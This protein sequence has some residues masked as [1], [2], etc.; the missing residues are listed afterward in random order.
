LNLK[1]RTLTY[2]LAELFFI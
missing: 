2:W 1:K